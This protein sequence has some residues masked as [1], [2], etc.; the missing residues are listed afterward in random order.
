[1]SF[2]PYKAGYGEIKNCNSRM[3]SISG[4]WPVKYKEVMKLDKTIRLVG[5][6]LT[7]S[8]S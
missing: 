7:A 1:M 8:M 5:D 4:V 6:I 2:I 3:H